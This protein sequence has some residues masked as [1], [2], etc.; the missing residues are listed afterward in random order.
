MKRIRRVVASAL[1]LC[2]AGVAGAADFVSV[3]EPTAVLYDAPSLKSNKLF[4]I[5]RFTPLE[6][7]VVLDTWIKVRDSSGALA[8]IEKRVASNKQFVAVV[9][10]QA[11]LR[12]APQEAA[13]TLLRI[14]R[15]VAL[16]LLERTGNGWIK[17]RHAGGVEGFVQTSDIWG[18]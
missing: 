18:I 7:V 8:W 9:V 1:M 4:V 14:K 12:D 11:N 13:A 3:A 5:S 15:N 6:Q 10:D 16:E 2:L 17:V